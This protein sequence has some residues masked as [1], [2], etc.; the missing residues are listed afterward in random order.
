TV[1]LQVTAQGSIRAP[2]L[3]KDPPWERFLTGDRIVLK[4][5]AG[6]KLRSRDYIW[7][8]NGWSN[9]TRDESYTIKAAALS[10]SGVYKCKINSS[11]STMN[12]SYSNTV[13]LAITEP[14]SLMTIEA[15][16]EI[17]WVNQRLSLRCNFSYGVSQEFIYT[18]Y[19]E[20]SNFI[21]IR[22]RNQSVTTQIEHVTLEDSGRY[23]CQAGFVQF[24]NTIYSSAYKR[25]TIEGMCSCALWI[26]IGNIVAHWV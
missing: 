5:D 26:D 23:L 22:S 19:R 13:R 10:N 11:T 15:V 2:R 7:D 17:L 12:T 3:T 16:P 21:E 1:T 4:C 6:I 18:F 24:P 14:D 8:I 20:G 9:I 25:V